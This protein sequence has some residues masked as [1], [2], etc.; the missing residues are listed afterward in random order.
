M[1]NLT[2]STNGE[3]KQVLVQTGDTLQSI[4][5]ANGVDTTGAIIMLKGT[6]VSAFDLGRTFAECNVS[7]GESVIMN[8]AVKASAAAM[9]TN[10]ENNVLTVVTDLTREIVEADISDLVARDEDGNEKFKVLVSTSGSGCLDEFAIVCNTYV[11]E[12]LAAVMVLPMDTTL[13]DVKHEFGESLLAADKYLKQITDEAI[14]KVANINEIFD[15]D[16]VEDAE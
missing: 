8:V 14:D 11:D 16:Q 6:P 7:D 3:R 2:L 12:K 4:V 13:D 5:N 15:T 10:Y 1:I 9:V